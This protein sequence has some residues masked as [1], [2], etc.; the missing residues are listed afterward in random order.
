MTEGRDV[1]EGLAMAVARF[2]TDEIR[3]SIR[4]DPLTKRGSVLDV[5]QLVTG[6]DQRNAS[7]NLQRV[8]DNHPAILPQL[9]DL[10][11]PGYKQKPTKAALIK[12]LVEIAWLCP[13]KYAAEFRQ[14]GAVML[15]RA[16]GGDPAL[17]EE[18]RARRGTVAVEAQEAL[19]A[20]TGVTAAEAN[21]Q[22]PVVPA[23]EQLR[24]YRAETSK[25]ETEARQAAL[26][27]YERMLSLV[28]MEEDERDKL[29]FQDAARNFIRGQF[30]VQDRE[31]LEG[32]PNPSNEQVTI[33]D[34]ARDLGVRLR[35]G[36]DSLVGKAAAMLY[37]NKH[38]E[39][40]PKHKRFVDGAVRAV[41]LYFEKD[42]ELLEQAIRAV[43]QQ[44]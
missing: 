8:L 40:P 7:R 31:L 28:G 30:R 23:D 26:D 10:K 24:R 3:R 9:I 16:L 39:G 20:G 25:I 33:A 17:V 36:E 43:T 32:P 14:S 15:C 37:R 21:A 35:R 42:R 27:A 44:A 1:R 18:I 38:G 19:L 22:A 13:G 6:C 29:F 4:F 5:V 2:T 11:F 12:D 34:V 41:N